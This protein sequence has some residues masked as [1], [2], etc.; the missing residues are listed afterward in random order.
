M[1]YGDII[2]TPAMIYHWTHLAFEF[3]YF[4]ECGV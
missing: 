1:I 4:A 3:I 2:Q